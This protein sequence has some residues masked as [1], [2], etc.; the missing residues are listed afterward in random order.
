[1]RGDDCQVPAG[2]WEDREEYAL[3]GRQIQQL[4]ELILSGSFTRVLSSAVTGFGR[5]QYDISV[6]FQD[7]QRFLSIHCLDGDYISIAN[8]FDGKHLKNNNR[9]WTDS[10]ER[11]LAAK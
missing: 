3:D 1:M 7:G 9:G 4:K 8:Q 10:L 11:I 2:E 6:D 5:T